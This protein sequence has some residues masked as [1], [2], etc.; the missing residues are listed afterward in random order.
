MVSFLHCDRPCPAA[1]NRHYIRQL[2][3]QEGKNFSHLSFGGPRSNSLPALTIRATWLHNTPSEVRVAAALPLKI[4]DQQVTPI[5]DLP[6]T[7]GQKV[8]PFQN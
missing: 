7:A 2:L 6:T 1:G 5:S 3:P 4:A 8:T